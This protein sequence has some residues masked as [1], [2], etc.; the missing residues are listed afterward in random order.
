MFFQRSGC[1]KLM[2][3]DSRWHLLEHGEQVAALLQL[4]LL[5]NHLRAQA[6][7]SYVLPACTAVRAPAPENPSLWLSGSGAFRIH[8]GQPNCYRLMKLLHL[9]HPTATI[10]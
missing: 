7:Q 9:L 8:P 6:S 1:W 4:R 2:D 10:G 5:D 3:R